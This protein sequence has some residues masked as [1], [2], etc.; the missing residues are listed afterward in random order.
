M[1]RTLCLDPSQTGRRSGP[2]V[3]AANS[4][5]CRGVTTLRMFVANHLRVLGYQLLLQRATT[6]VLHYFKTSIKRMF[7]FCCISVVFCLHFIGRH[8]CCSQK[9]PVHLVSATATMVSAVSARRTPVRG[10]AAHPDPRTPRD[11]FRRSS[12]PA[13]PAWSRRAGRQCR[14][15]PG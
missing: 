5:P 4:A 3:Q 12:G 9:R 15:A 13:R 10:A 8:F 7:S 11:G 14:T 6:K 2:A 1:K